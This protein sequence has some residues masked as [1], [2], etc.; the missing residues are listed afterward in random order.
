MTPQIALGKRRTESFLQTIGSP[1]F[2]VHFQESI[3]RRDFQNPKQEVGSWKHLPGLWYQIFQ[4]IPAW[5]N[6][7]DRSLSNT[8]MTNAGLFSARFKKDGCEDAVP[9]M[10]PPHPHGPLSQ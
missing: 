9:K 5:Y 3:A 10:E 2:H 1:D 8:R 6:N 7:V 4:W